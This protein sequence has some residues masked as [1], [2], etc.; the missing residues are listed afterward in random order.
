[1]GEKTKKA[2]QI[3][4]EYIEDL[5]PGY[6]TLNVSGRESLSGSL[7][8]NERTDDGSDF[9]SRKYNT[10]VLNVSFVIEKETDLE[11][12][13]ALEELANIIDVRNARII[14]DDESDKFYKASLGEN[15][16]FGISLGVASGTFELYCA[17]PFKYDVD[18]TVVELSTQSY[19]D[20]D[21]TT[22]NALVFNTNNDGYKV[23][24]RFEVS[25]DKDGL[26][27]GT[28]DANCGYIMFAKTNTL[29][30]WN[31][32]HARVLANVDYSI[33][34]EYSNIYFGLNADGSDKHP[35]VTKIA[36]TSEGE[37]YVSY[38][39]S[40]NGYIFMEF[41][42]TDANVTVVPANKK[43]SS[44][45]FGSETEQ[46]TTIPDI[47]KSF[48]RNDKTGWAYSA[49][50][51][52]PASLYVAD[53][54]NSVQVSANGLYSTYNVT[55][56][57]KKYYGPT[58]MYTLPNGQN[59]D[60]SL[61]WKQCLYT[62][63]TKAGCSQVMLLDANKNP[64]FTLSVEKS[65]KTNTTGTVKFYYKNARQKQWKLTSG[66]IGK[67]GKLGYKLTSK[68]GAKTKTYAPRDAEN[69]ISRKDD[70]IEVCLSLDTKKKLT[71]TETEISTVKYV[72][73]FFG[74]YSNVTK[75][76]ENYI[77][78]VKFT[79]VAYDTDNAFTSTDILEVDCIDMSVT[80]NGNDTPNLGDISND[81][82][83]MVLDHGQNN[84]V[85]QWSDWVNPLY[86]PQA[87]MFYR[88]RWI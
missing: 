22:Q 80:L 81:W 20:D 71:F 39:P 21:G 74:K 86:S 79:G 73:F 2:M 44:I 68:K 6:A 33:D 76:E 23:Q 27:E 88:K 85:C 59:G 14:F 46:F 15:S 40:Y 60:F 65:N 41:E 17:D 70:K 4:G 37:S 9:I 48:I 52:M 30:Q 26:A 35:I 43:E 61:K 62:T 53:N 66:S 58:V 10:R 25:F 55:H 77:R 83:D 34:A 24:P 42:N 11:L 19:T 78:S 29:N 8:V 36:T 87:T 18:E 31:G 82:F 67:T 56:T 72:A 3:N 54:S 45:M 1:M 16:E 75:F 64:I 5:I 12:K 84:V 7:S 57:D 49:P 13:R 32:T 51:S 28:R 47:D 38:T 69:Y 50:A 63:K